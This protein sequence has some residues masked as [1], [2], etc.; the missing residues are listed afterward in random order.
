MAPLGADHYAFVDAVS[1]ET[2]G[3]SIDSRTPSFSFERVLFDL[4]YAHYGGL[5]L[6]GLYALL[7]LA[8]CAVLVTGNLIWLERR[9]EP[10]AHRGNRLL[11]RLTVGVSGG[12]VLAAAVYFASNRAL[13]EA[14]ARRADWEFGLFLGA[15]ALAAALPLLPL[16]PRVPPLRAGVWLCTGAAVLYAGVAASDVVFQ[17]AH[18]FTALARGLP[19]VF[20]TE[21]LLCALALGCGSLARGLA[22]ATTN[23]RR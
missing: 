6:K 15:W 1:G 2:F 9:D 5:L 22:R 11:E 17:E 23:S 16:L 20:L 14:L 21:V 18:L 13:P 19:S 12:L 4:H 8:L 7:A 3:T 10:R